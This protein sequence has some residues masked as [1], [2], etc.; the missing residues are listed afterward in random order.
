MKLDKKTRIVL[1]FINAECVE[2]SYKVIPNDDFLNLFTKKQKITLDDVTKIIEDLKN[3]KLIAFKYKDDSSFLITSTPDGKEFFTKTEIVPVV[4]IK[5]SHFIIFSLLFLGV[6][7]IGGIISSL[8][9][10]FVFKIF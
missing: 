10:R 5:K 4:K 8:M 9:M 3:K 7:I 6:A 1:S 2:G